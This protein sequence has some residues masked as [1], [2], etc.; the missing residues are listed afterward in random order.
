M[1][2]QMKHL[3][4]Y[5]QF[6]SVISEDEFPQQGMAARAAEAIVNGEA[7]TD[8]N[9]MLNLSSFVTTFIEPENREIMARNVT[10]NYIDHDMYPQLFAMEHRMVK[11]LHE[12]WNGPKGVDIYGTATVGSSEACM[13]GG[14]AHKWNWREAREKAGKDAVV[15]TWS[16]A[17]TCRSSGRS[18]CATSTLNHVSR[19]Y[20]PGITD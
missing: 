9:A 7:W 15:R 12:L 19:R 18:S 5:E 6:N 8:C 17:A 11:W 13:L 20:A 1:N 3:P 10:K 16:R 14:L 2:I 4:G